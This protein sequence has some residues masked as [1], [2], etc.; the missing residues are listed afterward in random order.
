MSNFRVTEHIPW[1]YSAGN[2]WVKCDSKDF[3]V[4]PP[5]IWEPLT[6]GNREEIRGMPALK[7]EIGACSL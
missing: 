6:E 3:D 4:A 7:G 2:L 5:G 1:M